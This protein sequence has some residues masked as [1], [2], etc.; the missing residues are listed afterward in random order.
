[1]A[2]DTCE[3]FDVSVVE[4]V[5]S[6]GT[7]C[8]VVKEGSGGHAGCFAVGHRWLDLGCES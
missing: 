7:S 2:E 5:E 4:G 6:D 8:V 1:M 3:E